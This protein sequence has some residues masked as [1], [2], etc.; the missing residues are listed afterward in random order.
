M[1]ASNTDDRM[2]VIDVAYCSKSLIY[3]KICAKTAKFFDW[4]RRVINRWILF[5]S[6]INNYYYITNKKRCSCV[7]MIR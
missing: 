2:L 7:R 1:Y 4:Y 5:T 3:T 6:E